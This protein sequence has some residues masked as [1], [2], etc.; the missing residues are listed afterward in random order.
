MVRRIFGVIICLPIL[1]LCSSCK[2]DIDITMIDIPGGTFEMGCSPGDSECLD[3]ENP[4]HTVTIS[5]FKMSAYEI[6]QGQWEALMGNNPADNDECGSNCPVELVY[7]NDVQDFIG[8]L[9]N[10]T[11]MNYRLPTEAEWEYAA[12]A[13][14]T[15]K[16]YCGDDE[17]CLDDIAWYDDN[18]GGQT[19]PVGQKEPNAWGLYDISGNVWEWCSDWYD[20]DYY[21]ISPSTDPQGPASTSVRVDRGGGSNS[22]AR[23]CRS[24]HRRYGYPS[25]GTSSLGFRLCL[26]Q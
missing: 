19:H 7:W 2:G 1:M 26:P 6:T 24:T 21:D 15:T 13:G 23:S 5:A 8:E 3:D 4:R 18:S 25:Y 14:T 22:V 16:W 11:G 20:A 10:Q 17:S 12:R 9:N